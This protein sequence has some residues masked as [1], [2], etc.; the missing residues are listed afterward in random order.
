M[1]IAR[2]KLPGIMAVSEIEV[3]ISTKAIKL[4]SRLFELDLKIPEEIDDKTATAKFI[5][6]TSILKLTMPRVI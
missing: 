1:V 4:A 3:D 6:K 5:K 2:I